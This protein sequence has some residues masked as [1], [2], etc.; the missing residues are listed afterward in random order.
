[1]LGGQGA[2]SDP[3]RISGISAERKISGTISGTWSGTLTVQRSY[4]NAETGFTINTLNTA[5][6]TTNGTFTYDD[7]TS[8]S[9]TYNNV[10]V[11]L[12]IGFANAGDYVSGAATITAQPPLGRRLLSGRAGRMPWSASPATSP[13]PR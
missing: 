4:T 13:R 10:I 9:G 7:V 1:M 11:W 12:R 5:T 8:E 2:F 3:L 6:F